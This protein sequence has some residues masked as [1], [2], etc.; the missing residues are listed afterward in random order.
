M[1]DPTFTK[2][3]S[4]LVKGQL[5]DFIQ[6]EDF[7]TYRLFVRDFYKFLESAKMTFATTTNY[8]IQEPT[9]TS[10]VLE[11]TGDRISLEDSVAFT[12]GETVTGQTSGA[13]ATVLVTDL[14]NSVIYITSNQ[15]FELNETVTGGTSGAEA[16]LTAYK[17]NPCSKYSTDVRLC[18]C[19]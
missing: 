1:H 9:T 15:R 5:P 16:K 3:V 12:V 11:E 7:E 8:L 14:R 13:T 6:D 2:K 19:W 17:T 18:K 10:Y 4:P